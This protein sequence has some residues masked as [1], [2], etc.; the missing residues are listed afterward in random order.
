MDREEILEK[1]CEIVSDVLAVHLKDVTP[2]SRF[3]Q[4]LGAESLQTAELFA[5]VEEEFEV[6]LDEE[7]TLRTETVSSTVDLLMEALVRPAP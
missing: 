6:E 5:I 2:Q 3:V 7:E 4:D 1:V